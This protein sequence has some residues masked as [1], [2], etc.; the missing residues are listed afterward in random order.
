MGS[1]YIWSGRRAPACVS[2]IL[3]PWTGYG[4]RKRCGSRTRPMQE[5]PSRARTG[6]GTE[7]KML[8]FSTETCVMCGAPI[9]EGR[10]V[11]PLCERRVLEETEGRNDAPAAQLDAAGSHESETPLYRQAEQHPPIPLRPKTQSVP[12]MTERLL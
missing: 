9:P 11:C 3:S 7:G 2:E 4:C 8:Y 10:Q 1:I 5:K 6:E 12:P